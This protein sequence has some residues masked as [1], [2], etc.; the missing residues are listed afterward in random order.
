MKREN[1]GAW[2]MFAILL[3]LVAFQLVVAFSHVGEQ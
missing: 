2:L 3:A 1:A